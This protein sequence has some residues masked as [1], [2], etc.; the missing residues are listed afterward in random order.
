VRRELSEGLRAVIAS[1]QT[2][3]RPVVTVGFRRVEQETPVTDEQKALE[4]QAYKARV[5]LEPRLK[6][7]EDAAPG[8]T[9]ILPAQDTFSRESAVR[10]EEVLLAQLRTALGRVVGAELL[11]LE[12]AG[13][14]TEPVIEVAYNIAPSGSLYLY[15]VT[16]PS[17]DDQVK[18]LLRG[19]DIRWIITLQPLDGGRPFLCDLE[20]TPAI[21]LNYDSRDGDPDWAPYAIMLYSAFHDMSA[22]LIEGFGLQPPQPPERFSFAEATGR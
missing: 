12:R 16:Q 1:L 9:A 6:E 3:D 21:N 7:V 14:G 4:R 11:A 10:R 2:A 8:R 18:G 22:R 17:K 19:Y 13:E 15:T 20:S 5:D